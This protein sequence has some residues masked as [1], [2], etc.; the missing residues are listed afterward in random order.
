MQAM[1]RSIDLDGD[2]TVGLNELRAFLRCYDPYD[3]VLKVKTA[4]VIIDVQNDFITGT[5]ANPYGAQAIVPAINKIR[6]LFDVVVISNDWHPH[7]H[8]SF[9]ESVNAGKQGCQGTCFYSW[10]SH[11]G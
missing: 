10:L 3:H 7:E 11:I 6:D 4:L 9:V 8:C 1:M 2:G 5:L